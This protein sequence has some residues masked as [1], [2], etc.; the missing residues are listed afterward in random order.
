MLGTDKQN[1]DLFP[2]GSWRVE[3]VIWQVSRKDVQ[4]AGNHPPGI[5]KLCFVL[6]GKEGLE[7][8]GKHHTYGGSR[9]GP[10]A[11]PR[12]GNVGDLEAEEHSVNYVTHLGQ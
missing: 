8:L 1:A 10:V 3:A 5:G 6:G 12:K 2:L 4:F 9:S 7:L 11:K